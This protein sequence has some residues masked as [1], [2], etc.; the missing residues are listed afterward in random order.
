MITGFYMI[1]ASVWKELKELRITRN[2]SWQKLFMKIKDNLY[3]QNWDIFWY[4][5]WYEQNYPYIKSWNMKRVPDGTPFFNLLPK[6]IWTKFWNIFLIFRS[7]S[8]N[9]F[10]THH[11]NSQRAIHLAPFLRIVYSNACVRNCTPL[12]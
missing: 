10:G 9:K 1:T 11:V 8:K 12:I 5:L 3:I 7:V 2:D 4:F 6:K